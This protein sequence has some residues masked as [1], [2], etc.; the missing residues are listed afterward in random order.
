[1][2]RRVPLV[3]QEL[4]IHPEHLRSSPVLSGVRGARSCVICVVFCRSLFVP[5]SFF[6]WPLCCLSFA[7][8]ILITPFCYFNLFLRSK[9]K[10]TNTFLNF[11]MFWILTWLNETN[12]GFVRD[13]VF[14][15]LFSGTNSSLFT[16]YREKLMIFEVTLNITT[17]VLQNVVSTYTSELMTL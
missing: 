16:C 12:Y 4:L 2:V 15:V 11:V 6:F 13:Y 17:G 9:S 5:L 14:S 7:L 8:R 3:E 10:W 1:L